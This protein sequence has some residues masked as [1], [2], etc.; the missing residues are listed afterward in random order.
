MS[1]TLVI[2]N[3]LAEGVPLTVRQMAERAGYTITQTH[4]ALQSLRKRKAVGAMDTPYQMTKEGAE[5][6][7]KRTKRNTRLETKRI[8]LSE[9]ERQARALATRKRSIAAKHQRRLEKRAA[10]AKA[11]TRD[12]VHR[13]VD[14]PVVAD[15]IVSTAVQS[16][17]ALQAAWGA[18][19]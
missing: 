14:A 9:E 10:L 13:Q 16:R 2:L 11:D 15:S 3:M 12:F 8:A 6:L 7:Q 5:W 18:M 4:D 19:A 1:Q 17:P